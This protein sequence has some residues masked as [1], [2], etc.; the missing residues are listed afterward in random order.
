VRIFEGILGVFQ[1]A[2][3]SKR[4]RIFEQ[5]AHL[6]RPVALGYPLAGAAPM[7]HE[8]AYP[9]ASASIVWFRNE[10]VA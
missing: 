8:R 2:H 9:L 5:G 6:R 1:D 4:L 10:H 7:T 3:F